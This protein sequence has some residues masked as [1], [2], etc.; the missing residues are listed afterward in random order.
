MTMA[1]PSTSSV[2]AVW[3]QLPA[4]PLRGRVIL[5][6]GLGCVAVFGLGLVVQSQFSTT[7][8]QPLTA[9]AAFAVW[10]AIAIGA[11]RH[12]HPFVRFGPANHVTMA[13]GM[14]VWLSAS[15]IAE[16]VGSPV[17]WALVAAT[18]MVVALDGVDGWLARRTR[19]NSAF[20]ARFDM[21]TDAFFMLV[22]SVLVW[23]H[24]KA[25]LWVLGIGLMRYAFVAA[26]WVL[27]WLSRPLR[28]TPRGKAAAMAQ[29]AGLGI[30]LVPLV[31]MPISTIV[32]A[33]A[34]ATLAWSFAIDVRFLWV[35]RPD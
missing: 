20:G 27:P 25:G 5:A 22:L 13:R 14:L 2:S 19:M 15:M 26:G 18:V 12:H 1:A 6:A 16:P 8:M 9:T 7:S 31:P 24:H 3:W 11:M 32:S 17:A 21:E 29:L 33:T 23:R 30:A 35:T 4:P 28:S 10:M 34:L